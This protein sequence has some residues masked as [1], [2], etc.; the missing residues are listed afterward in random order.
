MAA[1]RRWLPA[2]A[3]ALP[4]KH[5][6]A[7]HLFCRCEAS[8]ESVAAISLCKEASSQPTPRTATGKV[9]AKHAVVLRTYRRSRHTDRVAIQIHFDLLNLN[10]MDGHMIGHR[11]YTL[12]YTAVPRPVWTQT[13]TERHGVPSSAH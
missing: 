13:T 5:C 11:W 10:V 3:Q 1:P 12:T 8:S 4:P 6:V 7:R 2:N 9:A